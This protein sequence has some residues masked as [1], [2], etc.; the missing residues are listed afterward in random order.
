[1]E[2]ADDLAELVAW[3]EFD[4]VDFDAI[5]REERLAAQRLSSIEAGR[6]KGG[7]AGAAIAAAMF[8]VGE[9]YEGP[10]K[11]DIEIAMEASGEPGDIDREG[12]RFSIGE[13]ELR[14][15]PPDPGVT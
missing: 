9:I 15:R 13:V 10:P 1:M 3:G 8:V 12:I 5:V 14:T 6:R 2:N 7:V 4:D 11:D